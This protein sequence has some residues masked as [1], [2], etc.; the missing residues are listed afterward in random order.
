MRL[1]IAVELDETWR[2]ALT[3]AIA[4]LSRRAR[5][6]R[7]VSSDQLHLTLKFLGDV[8]SEQ[9]SGIVDAVR[10]ISRAGAP[11]EL[12]AASAGTFP[13]RGNP[14]VLWVGIDDPIDGCA[15]WVA[16]SAAPL[17]AL[18]FPPEARP[19]H[20]HITLARA[21]TPAAGRALRPAQTGFALPPLPPL[22]VRE[23]VLFRSHLEPR[24]ARYEVIARAPLGA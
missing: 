3:S 2:T 6:A 12:H 24:G 21:K 9:A 1:F 4:K 22:T 16:R 10:A 5:D 15:A 7:W 20:P 19:F 17:A 8:A 18:G 14:R 13:P 23:V 11:F